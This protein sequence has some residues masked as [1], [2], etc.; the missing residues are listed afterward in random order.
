[1]F[2]YLS[3]S[4][5]H[6][7]QL[8]VQL[9]G[10]RS[11]YIHSTHLLINTFVNNLYLFVSPRILFSSLHYIREVSKDATFFFKPKGEAGT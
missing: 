8:M 9:L 10:P 3:Y 2:V 11:C 5:R 4:Y 1:M 7:C 6:S